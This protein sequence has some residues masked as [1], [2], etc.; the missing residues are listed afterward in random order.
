MTILRKKNEK[1]TIEDPEQLDEYGK[2]KIV[3]DDTI[4]EP[5]QERQDDYV[6]LVKQIEE[7]YAP[8]FKTL[9][10][11]NDEC[12]AFSKRK[13]DVDE[14]KKPSDEEE[15]QFKKDVEDK[16]KDYKNQVIAINSNRRF[17]EFIFKHPISDDVWKDVFVA[18]VIEH[19]IKAYNF[20]IESPEQRKNAG[21]FLT[22]MTSNLSSLLKTI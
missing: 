1:I 15:K 2:A 9:M 22:K 17:I 3:F 21:D 19:C 10:N 18:S 11:I 13:E 6:D 16:L 20:M 7:E 12:A 8:H 5:S 14:S 4:Y